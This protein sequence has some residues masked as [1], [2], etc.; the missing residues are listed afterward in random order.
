MVTHKISKT[1]FI[2]AKK[3]C[4]RGHFHIIV[5]TSG[6]PPKGYNQIAQTQALSTSKA[7]ESILPEKWLNTSKNTSLNQISFL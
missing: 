1:Y 2:H 6:T 3:S 5:T 4:K 7:L